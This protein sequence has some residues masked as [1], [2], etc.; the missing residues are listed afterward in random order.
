MVRRSPGFREAFGVCVGANAI[1]QERTSSR[2][3]PVSSDAKALDGLNVQ[4]AVCDEIASHKTAEVYDVLLTAMGSRLARPRMPFRTMLGGP[5][6]RPSP[7]ALRPGPRRPDRVNAAEKPKSN[8]APTPHNHFI[9]ASGRVPD[10]SAAPRPCGGA[11]LAALA[12]ARPPAATPSSRALRPGHAALRRQRG[13][14]CR[15]TTACRV[16][17]AEQAEDATSVGGRGC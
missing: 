17:V 14:P 10:R 1:H 13:R 12:R 2:F 9:P 6:A 16:G 5:G 8:R 4:V 3:A 15:V 7:R 11:G